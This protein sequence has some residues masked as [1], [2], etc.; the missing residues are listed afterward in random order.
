MATT[1]DTAR[2]VRG[3][4]PWPEVAAGEDRA[5][6]IGPARR[7]EGQG[8]AGLALPAAQPQTELTTTMVVPG[9][10]NRLVDELGRTQLLEPQAG[11]AR[12]A[13]A[14]GNA[15]DTWD[16][17]CDIHPRDMDRRCSSFAPGET[18]E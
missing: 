5:Q 13:S 2:S 1:A 14:R 7:R 15:P 12:R 10:L 6:V 3:R 16:H 17:P 8:N 11:S 18:I 9:A 4:E